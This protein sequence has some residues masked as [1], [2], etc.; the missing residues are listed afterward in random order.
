MGK[1]PDNP[2]VRVVLPI[3]TYRGRCGAPSEERAAFSVGATAALRACDD[4]QSERS[5]LCCILL[6]DY[7]F[8]LNAPTMGLKE[9]WN[10]LVLKFKKKFLGYVEPP[11][12]WA[13][14]VARTAAS[15]DGKGSRQGKVTKGDV[16]DW[17]SKTSKDAV[18]TSDDSG[19]KS[20][21]LSSA[22]RAAIFGLVEVVE[23]LSEDLR[24]V[25]Y[26]VDAIYKNNGSMNSSATATHPF[27]VTET[28]GDSNVARN[29]ATEDNDDLME[30]MKQTERAWSVIRS[31]FS[32][33]CSFPVSF[34]SL[35]VYRFKVGPQA[36]YMAQ[37]TLKQVLP[38]LLKCIIATLYLSR[39]H[40]CESPLLND[41]R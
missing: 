10:D 18:R 39:V 26:K 31:H 33:C 34:H 12:K 1:L 23:K 14:S 38:L 3:P 20:P 15:R 29:V 37:K 21:G 36:R 27:G 8:A 7:D 13:S 6:P 19:S 9:V 30:Q 28:N 32:F 5:F 35:Y 22:D 41:G 2:N 17:L 16:S 40:E 24:I 4:S 25:S 11:P